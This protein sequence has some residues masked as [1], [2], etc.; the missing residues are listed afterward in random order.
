MRDKKRPHFGRQK[1]IEQNVLTKRNTF[2]FKS[3]LFGNRAVKLSRPDASQPNQTSANKGRPAGDEGPTSRRISSHI[4]RNDF[5]R[6][7][8]PFLTES[9][10]PGAG[11]LGVAMAICRPMTKKFVSRGFLGFVLFCLPK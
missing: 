7:R 2:G 10:P 4:L 1:H 6:A 5:V 3:K 8:A 9:G 11:R